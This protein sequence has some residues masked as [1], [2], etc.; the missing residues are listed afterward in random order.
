[1]IRDGQKLLDLLFVFWK[2]PK[3]EDVPGA[4][5]LVQESS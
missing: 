5:Y 3:D 2:R 1:M 4:R